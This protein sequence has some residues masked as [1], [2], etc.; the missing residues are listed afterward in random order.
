MISGDETLRQLIMKS[1]LRYYNEPY[2]DNLIFACN[3]FL[4]NT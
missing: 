1:M 4:K 3:Y 2:C